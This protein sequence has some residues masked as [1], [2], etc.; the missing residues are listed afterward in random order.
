MIYYFKLNRVLKIDNKII[1]ID[2]QSIIF[3]NRYL[4]TIKRNY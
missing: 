3:L 1:R 2:V 4:N